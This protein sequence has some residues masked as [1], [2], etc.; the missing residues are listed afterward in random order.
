MLLA[1]PRWEGIGRSN[2]SPRPPPK[3]AG[4][5][6]LARDRS[7][8]PLPPAPS[9]KRGGG[10]LLLRLAGCGDREFPAPLPATG[11][12]R[13]EGFRIRSPIDSPPCPANLKFNRAFC[14]LCPPRK[15]KTPRRKRGH[16]HL[17]TALAARRASALTD[18]CHARPADRKLRRHRK[19]A[20]GR[21]RRQQR[22]HRLA[23]PAAVRLAQR[24]PPRQMA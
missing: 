3:R 19:P 18:P 20:D 23:V 7:D 22:L 24:H 14:Y 9:P 16:P 11:R 5:E 8:Q 12:G 17:Q 15:R 4:G 10:E 1:S 13:G 6:I 2:P 21:P